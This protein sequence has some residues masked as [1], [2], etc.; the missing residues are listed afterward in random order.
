MAFIRP[1]KG[2]SSTVGTISR[3]KGHFEGWVFVVL[4]RAFPAPGEQT[5]VFS[6]AQEVIQS[7]FEERAHKG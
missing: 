3:S 6:R 2:F 1:E 4:A 7:K 5:L